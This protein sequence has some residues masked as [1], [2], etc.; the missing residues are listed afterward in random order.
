[1]RASKVIPF[2]LILTIINEAAA[3]TERKLGQ[4]WSALVE[5]SD[6]FDKEK[7]DIIQVMKSQFTFRCGELNMEVS[8]Y[9]F[10]SISFSADLQ[11]MVDDQVPIE[12]TGMYSTY[13]G[14][15]D[16]VTNSRY[17]SFDLS[18]SDVNAM[19]VGSSV[20]VAGTYGSSGWETK[21][22]NLMGFTSAYNSMCN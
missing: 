8:S 5:Q 17:F 19:K 6:P 16:M 20:K 10:E 7:L 13:L 15:S 14:G 2:I 3:Y 1:M 4:G 18:E 9:G 21:T 12:K 11:Y 22:L